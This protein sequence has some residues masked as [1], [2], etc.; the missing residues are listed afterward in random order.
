MMAVLDE[1]GPNRLLNTSAFMI[2]SIIHRAR[3]DVIC[4]AHSHSVYGRA[5]STLGIELSILTQDSRSFYKAWHD[6]WSNS[7]IPFRT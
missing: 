7:M 6:A 4:A 2:H 3:P 5:F 1:S